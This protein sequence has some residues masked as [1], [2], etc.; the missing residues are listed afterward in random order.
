MLLHLVRGVWQL[1]QIL[2]RFAAPQ[3]L[4]PGESPTWQKQPSSQ[5][6]LL[7]QLLDSRD[8]AYITDH[9]VQHSFKGDVAV[10]IPELGKIKLRNEV[11]FP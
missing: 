11:T 2:L 9:A 7:E 4:S 10:L 3:M 8:F 5:P 1:L 6:L